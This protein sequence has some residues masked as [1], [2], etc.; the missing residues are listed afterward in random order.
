MRRFQ[1]HRDL[2]VARDAL[3]E[4][5]AALAE[6]GWVALHDHPLEGRDQPGDLLILGGRDR[7]RI[8]KA[9]AVVQL[10]PPPGATPRG[11]PAW[12]PIQRVP[13]LRGNGARGHAIVERVLPED[14]HKAAV[15]AL[16]V[17]EEQ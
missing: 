7:R 14:A 1:S 5:E 9:A 10:D 12:Q 17:G 2:Q 3:P 6:H 15:R 11:Y 13:D 8:E 16:A 4:P